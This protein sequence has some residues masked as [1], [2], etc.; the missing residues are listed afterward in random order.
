MKILGIFTLLL[1]FSMEIYSQGQIIPRGEFK[2]ANVELRS[3]DV[4]VSIRNGVADVTM[5]QVFFNAGTMPLEGDYIL[6]L[7]G[8]AQVYDFYLEIDGKKVKGEMLEGENARRIYQDIVR[9]F[10]DP[11]LLEYAGNG[12]F[13]AR[14]F[15]IDPK[16]ERKIRIRYAAILS[17]QFNNYDF[18]LPQ[19]QQSDNPWKKSHIRVEIREDETIGNIY[20]PS[21]EL[22]FLEKTENWVLLSAESGPVHLNKDFR[23]FY[24]LA[25]EGMSYSLL[26]FRPRTDRDGYFILQMNFPETRMNR[27]EISR[28]IIFVVDV[29]GSMQGEKIS[30]ARNALRSC[31]NSLHENDYFEIISF[32]S[33]I[34]SFK[35]NLVRADRDSKENALYFIDNLSSAGGTNINAALKEALS[36]QT[37]GQDKTSDIIFVTDGLP[38]EGET[39]IQAILNNVKKAEGQNARIF[40]FGVGWDVNTY[41]LDKLSRENRG[42][43]EYVKPDEDIESAISFLFGK[44]ISPVLTN[45]EVDFDEAGIY[46]F[47]PVDIPDLFRGERLTLL[48]RYSRTGKFTLRIKGRLENKPVSFNLPVHL[49]RRETD[50][51]FISKLWANRKVSHL[52]SKIRFKGETQELVE[53]VKSLAMEYGIVTPYTSYLVREQKEE[54]VALDASR[55]RGAAGNR[56]LQRKQALEGE[57][58][59]EAEI[60]GSNSFFDAIIA[61]PVAPQASSGKKAVL[62]SV[63]LSKIAHNAIESDMLLTVRRVEERTFRLKKGVWMEE[64]DAVSGEV[65]RYLLFLSDEYFEFLQNNPEVAKILALGENILFVWRNQIIRIRQS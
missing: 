64:N 19:Y 58:S 52:L 38:T 28:N 27:Q 14:I 45:I 59:G 30:Q 31:I 29:S 23:L 39:H 62:S 53:S 18:R 9:K 3:G 11:A 60:V 5:D 65:D 61:L 15:P 20:S 12:I 25:V 51:S 36:L 46:D 32:S 33:T 34:R 1:F 44:I 40:S 4:S 35:G 37:S 41:L 26:S 2:P 49:P 56:I 21:H 22:E 42:S 13:R 16:K 57:D 55:E 10:R 63:G 54:L 50:N 17:S 6:I 43:V 24:S 47:Y 48:G 8:E 7:P